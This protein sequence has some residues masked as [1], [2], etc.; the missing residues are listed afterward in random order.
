MEIV[1]IVFISINLFGIDNPFLILLISII[2]AIFLAF[3]YSNITDYIISNSFKKFITN[4]VTIIHLSVLSVI[5]YKLITIPINMNDITSASILIVI[6]YYLLSI[7]YFIL[8]YC[9]D[10]SPKKKH[11]GLDRWMQ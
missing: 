8:N 1:G 6:V 4:K 11:Y 9:L 5:I 7:F 2:S 3:G 10:D